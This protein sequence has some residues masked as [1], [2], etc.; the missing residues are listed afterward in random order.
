MGKIMQVA[1][2]CGF[3]TTVTIGGGMRDH[4][5]NSSFPHY[6][7][8]C[9]MVGVNVMAK[10][11]ECPHCHSQEVT[12][13]GVPPVSIP[14]E[15]YSGVQWGNYN[16]PRSGNLCPQCKEMTLEFTSTIMMFD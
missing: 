16:A 6:C 10:P 11:I 2:P 1:C 7:K 5:T 13:Y 14:D 9:G 15:Q 4:R 8:T 12:A 3:E